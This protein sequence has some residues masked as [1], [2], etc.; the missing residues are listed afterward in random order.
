MESKKEIVVLGDRDHLILRPTVYV[1][2][3]NPT[4]EKTPI[5]R[6]GRIYIENRSISVGMY[7]LFDEVFS[8]SLD[9]AKR[10][11]GKMERILVSVDSQKNSIAVR[12]SG[13]GFY[14]GASINKTS[15]KTNIETAVSMFR[16]GSNF[17]NDEVDESLIGTNGLGLACVCGLSKDFKIITINES[18]Y[19][20]QEWDDFKTDGPVIRKKNSDESRGTEIIFKPLRS[21]FVN[22]KWDRE[23]LS[24]ILILK[25]DLIKKDPILKDLRL[26]LIWDGNLIDLSVGFLPADSYRIETEIGQIAIWEKYEGSGAV[27]FVNSALCTGIH[28]KIFNDFINEKLDDTLGHHFYDTYITLNLPPKAVRFGDQN[29]TKFV[30][31]REEVEPHISRNFGNK[32]QAFFKTPLFES[33]KKK[34]DDRKNEGFVKKLKA[35]KRKVNLK[36]S[37][38]YF[39]ADRSNADNLFIVEGL[40]AMGSI[41]QKRDPKNDGV[42][43]LKGKIKNCKTIGDLSENKEI[44]EL[45]HILELDPTVKL[46]TLSGYKRAIISADADPDGAHITS[47]VINLFHR[48][49]PQVIKSGQLMILRTPLV[50]VGDGKRRKYY[51]NLNDFKKNHKGGSGPVRYL[52]G[53]GSLSSEDWE[54]VMEN[55]NLISITNSPGDDKYLDMAFGD[56][57]DLRKKWLSGSEIVY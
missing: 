14:K 11:R 7:K 22:T 2:S 36:N 17:S 47:L 35:E 21:V 12:D 10:M 1:G 51:F 29:K 32:I 15:G 30:S 56:S 6:G 54:Y 4:D 26:E 57:S 55:K 38:K 34:V 42:Y 16:A 53:L 5:I 46:G 13:D 50:S 40:S 8:N 39:P 52:K 20:L 41:L 3:V 48:W 18:H 27:S 33:I 19:Y 9:E 23:I 28:Q 37:H 49:F 44:L 25:Y 31:Q 45:M 24:S 43:A